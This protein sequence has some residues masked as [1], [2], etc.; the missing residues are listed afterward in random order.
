[1]KN[2]EALP[3][4]VTGCGVQTPYAVHGRENVKD[5]MIVFG[6]WQPPCKV[7]LVM[8]DIKMLN[9][10]IYAYTVKLNKSFACCFIVSI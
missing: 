7:L 9:N 5:P 8:G 1:L 3:I 2:I 4:S 10:I 6:Q